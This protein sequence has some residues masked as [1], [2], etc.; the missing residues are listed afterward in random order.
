MED[1]VIFYDRQDL[2]AYLEQV[3]WP[4]DPPGLISLYC[5]PSYSRPGAGWH[6]KEGYWR[7]GSQVFIFPREAARA[8]VAD[9]DV[10]SYRWDHPSQGLHGVDALIGRWA[11]R[12]RIPVHYPCPGLAQHIGDTSTL[13]QSIQ[14]EPNRRADR[15]LGDLEPD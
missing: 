5:P 3:L 2:R 12:R 14:L 6:R 4:S 13:W 8:F 10:L 7:A 11:E 9:L 1:D 15:F